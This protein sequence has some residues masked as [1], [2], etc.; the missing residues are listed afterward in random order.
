M[1]PH[2]PDDVINRDRLWR[3]TEFHVAHCKDQSAGPLSEPDLALGMG[4]SSGREAASLLIL[5]GALQSMQSP[6]GAQSVIAGDPPVGGNSLCLPSAGDS[7]HN[8]ILT[9]IT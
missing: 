9:T 3:G 8:S 6:H 4:R 7:S 2:S 1:I 5:C